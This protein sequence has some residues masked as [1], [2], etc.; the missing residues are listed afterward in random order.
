M[1][2]STPSQ[3]RMKLEL[4]TWWRLKQKTQ[5]SVHDAASQLPTVAR[6]IQHRHVTA[7]HATHHNIAEFLFTDRNKW[8]FQQ[9]YFSHDF[10]AM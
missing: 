1:H 2:S 9:L 4:L 6:A 3:N 8:L 10:Q 7:C 5:I